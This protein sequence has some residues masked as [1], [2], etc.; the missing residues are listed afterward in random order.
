M[1]DSSFRPPNLFSN[2]DNGRSPDQALLDEEN[3]RADGIL[4]LIEGPSV[5]DLPPLDIE[6][7]GDW[8]D[9]STETDAPPLEHHIQMPSSS[10]LQTQSST[11]ASNNQSDPSIP[12]DVDDAAS[13]ESL[14][15]SAHSDTPNLAK[16][17]EMST[18]EPSV[19]PFDNKDLEQSIPGL[20][21]ILDLVTEQGSGGLGM[22]FPAM[23]GLTLTLSQVDK[24]IISQNSLKTFINTISPGAYLSMTKVN[25]KML[26]QST[27]K[28]VGIYGSKEEIVRF[29]LR[30]HAVD[31][32]IATHLLSESSTT[33]AH[34]TLRS[35]LYILR[36]S[37]AE[38]NGSE[39]M[40]LTRMCD[41]IVALVSSEH[42][43]RMVWSEIGDNG[44]DDDDCVDEDDENDR[45]IRCVVQR[46]TEQEESVQVR[47]GFKI[48]SEHISQ[49]EPSECGEQCSVKP[50]LLLG[51]A[52]QGFVTVQHHPP[53]RVIETL[54][55]RSFNAI[56]L[57][58]Y[59]ISDSLDISETLDD[60][61]LRILVD[62]G[63][64]KRCP[65]E[66]VNWEHQSTAIQER[67]KKIF[68]DRFRKAK[69]ELVKVTES[70]SSA[71]YNAVID[72][73]VALY[74]FIDKQAFQYT[75]SGTEDP[76]VVSFSQITD[77][78]PDASR[79]FQRNIQDC[80]V[81]SD[82]EFRATKDRL[83]L[84]V[85]LA[86]RT[87]GLGSGVRDP[88]L[89]ATFIG[90]FR[91][92][93]KVAKSL[94]MGS[95]SKLKMILD[96]CDKLMNSGLAPQTNTH[97][98]DS[99]LKEAHEAALKVTDKK[100]SPGEGTVSTELVEKA[101][102]KAKSY[103]EYTIPRVVMKI[104]SSFKG[105]QEVGCR[106]KIKAE[107]SSQEDQE[108]YKYRLQLIQHVN[109]SSAQVQCRHTLRIDSVEE[110]KKAW[111]IPKTYRLWGLR[112][113]QED[114]VTCYTVHPMNVTE[115][116]K[117]NLQLDPSS[118]PSPRFRFQHPF[119]L[120]LGHTI[121]RAQLLERERLLLIVADRVGNI[122]VYLET[123]TA[124]HGAIQ[125]GHCKALKREKIGQDFHIAFDESKRMLAVVSSDKLLL[126][127]FV[128][129]DV[130]GF[131][132]QGSA[133]NL[134]PWYGE[135]VRIRHAC[136]ICGSEEILLVDS[137][138]Q[139]RVFS[140][141][142]MQF[143]PAVLSLPQVPTG[144]HCTPD[145]SCVLVLQ[146][147]ESELAVTAYHWSSFGS[148]EGISLNIPDLPVGEPLV[149]T[150]LIKRTAVHLLKL[151]LST[152]CC[153]SYAL[154]ITRRH[155]EFMFRERVNRN[156]TSERAHETAHNCLIDCHSEVWTRFPVC[157]AVPR[158]TISSASL[159]GQKSLVFVT[160]RSFDMFAPHFSQ[161]IHSFERTAKK[162]TGNALKSVK[163]SAASF[164]VFAQE[165][166][167]GAT[168]NV[169]QYRAG[170]WIVDFLCLIP[171]HIAVTKDNR[172]I[173]LKDGV[174][175]PSL[176]RELL[177]AGINRIVDNIS[178]GWYE[179]LFQ[180][181][182][183]TKVASLSHTMFLTNKDQ[184]VRVV[185]SMGEQSV[186]KS[187][188]LNHLV[189]TSFAGSAMR[190]TEGV[191]MS[192]TPTE[193][194][195]IVAL[196]FEG[197]HSIERS[198]QE[199]TLL[200]LFNTAISNLSSA[201]VLDPAENP[202][203]FQSTL[204]I[205]IKDV[206]EADKVEIGREF[207]LKFEKIVQ[208]EQEAN[209]ITRLHAGRL[210]IIPWP[211]IESKEFYKLFTKLKRC[212]DQQP[213][214]H[215]AA[216]EFLHKMKTLMAKLKANDWGAMSQTM[217]SH[218]AQLLLSLLPNALI[219]GLQEVAPEPEPLKSR[220][221]LGVGGFS[222][223]ETREQV[224]KVLRKSWDRNEMRQHLS[225]PE[226][227]DG[228]SQYLEQIVNLRID[229]TGHA[230]IE[231]LRRTFENA[232]VDLRSNVQLCRLQCASCQLLCIQSRLH[233]GPHNC[234]TDH[235]CI[236]QCDFC[237]EGTGENRACSMICVVNAHLC[238]KP[239]KFAGKFGC[240]HQ[241]TK[242]TDHP[243]EHLCAALVHGCGE[244]CDLSGIKLIDGS[245]YAC[246]GTCRVPSEEHLCSVDCSVPGICEIETAPYSIEATFT[247]RHETFQY[248]KYSQVAK[249]LKCAKSI[250]PG[251]IKHVGAHNHSLDKKVVHFCQNKGVDDPN[252]SPGHPQQEH[253]TR[254]G[255][256]S[257]TRWIVDESDDAAALEV[258]G[259]K[260]STDDE[261]A[262]MMCNLIEHIAK[263]LLPDPDR[264][265][266]Y[267][268]HS[269][270]WKKSGA[271]NPCFKDP[272]SKEEQANFAKCIFIADRSGSMASQDK[273]PLPNT[274]ASGKISARSN[275]RF[276]AVLS[277]LYG[278]WS[279]RSAAIGSSASTARRDAYSVILFNSHVTPIIENDFTSDA[280][281][282]LDVVLPHAANGG[283]NFTAAITSAAS[284]MER[285]W[286]TERKAV[287]FHAV[288]F[289]R[290][291]QSV[292]SSNVNRR[293]IT[294]STSLRRMVQIA[295]DTQNN[296]PR[297]PLAP[298]SVTVMSSYTDALDTVQLAETFL[299]IAESL[300]KPRGMQDVV[301]FQVYLNA[302][303]Q[304][305]SVAENGTR[306]DIS[307][308]HVTSTSMHNVVLCFD[309]HTRL[310]LKCMTS[311]WEAE[312]NCLQPIRTFP[313]K[314]SQSMRGWSMVHLTQLIL[315]ITLELMRGGHSFGVAY[316]RAKYFFPLHERLATCAFE[317]EHA[318]GCM[319]ID[320]VEKSE[321]AARTLEAAAA[322][323]KTLALVEWVTDD[324][325]AISVVP[326]LQGNTQLLVSR[327]RDPLRLQ[328]SLVIFERYG[329]PPDSMGTASA[330]SDTRI[331]I[332]LTFN[333]FHSTHQGA[334][335]QD[336]H[337][338]Q[339]CVLGI[340]NFEK[341][342]FVLTEN[343]YGTIGM[344]LAL[345]PSSKV[346]RNS[347]QEYLFVTSPSGSMNGARI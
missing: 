195:L 179:S 249:R 240:L 304:Y 43:R 259:R 323:G 238:G 301:T 11:A 182:M 332:K 7:D 66:C 23:M 61:G 147:H 33:E 122:F 159:R 340:V 16:D 315:A 200:V 4:T 303:A 278:F 104:V 18:D 237:K 53:K 329:P 325:L 97:S 236:H 266:D 8:S 163:V 321:V 190:T 247:G 117:H 112:E 263:R 154:D 222:Q 145:G 309:L 291:S 127:V 21:R 176:E 273:K 284:V 272:Y 72:D 317:L 184:P 22:V 84:L 128:Y 89:R 126:H 328:L 5:A 103:F 161:M 287:S 62:V 318:D 262:P 100:E 239:C 300:R 213:V 185:S 217:A 305:G 331:D 102:Q 347:S 24:I 253:E 286:S 268:T 44:D 270:F 212:L 91:E 155:T 269:L 204:V 37:A 140:L 108:R 343:G 64:R 42:A 231:E 106:A 312:S 116:D 158:E 207:S 314:K 211:V 157:A 241:C 181:Y 150:S 94:S 115:E 283:T 86:S 123:L 137:Q 226:W 134:G 254:H 15:E 302:V 85:E 203:L 208:D 9:S 75:G 34:P 124:M 113:S 77:T 96:Y 156:S 70:L 245:T 276:G 346:P 81:I 221:F 65:Q 1:D 79:V 88:I 264:P 244:P 308:H 48:T 46:T 293:Q 196:D 2:T 3:G 26:D 162:P 63:L 83:C 174:Y 279:A 107:C 73:V 60:K 132:A 67:Y 188:A 285:H 68:D 12:D 19:D 93:E 164:D 282:L 58:D 55:G 228:L 271:Y 250:P 175:S 121:L 336:V 54:K 333:Q 295:Q 95:A 256:M 280:N 327:V 205:I 57:E 171:I 198:A 246:P 144:V 326:F 165:L 136:F 101:R 41:Q 177:G 27:I 274:P 214:T 194:E 118:I 199:D 29:L 257:S 289:G 98:I 258:E 151:D 17:H 142:T 141:V 215:P 345:V 275:N 92:A 229:H 310:K 71:A 227:A 339:V 172:F 90:G 153:Q 186:G 139:A 277:S 133:I 248:T 143:R 306:M 230:S 220:L 197:V 210:N 76:P 255:S 120:P 292:G 294:S 166:C 261:G 344:Q 31:D 193:K 110:E 324:I 341:R 149:V 296:A 135:G 130:R 20:Y 201:T 189:D 234:R 260:F 30:L 219:Y 138:A 74:P 35:G 131:Q 36:S 169:S 47:E 307:W 297:D 252:G 192:V 125:R 51:E 316:G 32:T 267:I 313:L 334:M 146:P 288:S 78:Y 298:A 80:H 170:E 183:A 187:Y 59:L 148:T 342:D 69:D 180:S 335:V 40:Y 87:K 281:Q 338:A 319:I 311:Q 337:W 14:Y 28:P 99:V 322:A 49:T 173:P 105:I 299:G 265:K 218:R 111:A 168:W 251:Q 13:E 10:Q 82:R 290:D 52:A 206:V 167:D 25:F 119:E 152:R 191:W 129:G 109:N 178:F 243:D 235:A 223:S 160:D 233:D 45:I 114:P 56:Q 330:T 6:L 225:D 209:F 224:L 232:S 38:P 202:S 50:F 242:V 216:G 39:Q 320:M